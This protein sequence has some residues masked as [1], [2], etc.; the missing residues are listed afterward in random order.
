ME[1]VEVG[2]RVVKYELIVS[3]G[4]SSSIR[5]N[6][7]VVI[8]FDESRNFSS[9]GLHFSPS[10]IVGRLTIPRLDRFSRKSRYIRRKFDRA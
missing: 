2:L 5:N 4:R 7:H 3:L 6:R 9:A 1:I 10:A 8:F